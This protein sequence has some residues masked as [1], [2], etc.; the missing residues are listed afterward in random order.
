VPRSTIALLWTCKS[1][2]KLCEGLREIGHRVGRA[3]VCEL[4]HRLDSSLQVNR[5]T[6]EGSNHPDR[7]AQFHHINDCVNEALAAGEPAISI[8]TKKSNWSA[9]SRMVGAS[10]APRATLNSGGA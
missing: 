8:D 1:A 4:L 6:R 10:G 9:I 3:L 5:K 2:H 7:D